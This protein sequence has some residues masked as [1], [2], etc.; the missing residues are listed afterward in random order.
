MPITSYSPDELVNLIQAGQ[1]LNVSRQ[2]V[3]TL[4]DTKKLK[5]ILI[6]GRQYLL[7]AE[8]EALKVDREKNAH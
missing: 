6:G 3:Y 1:L 2:W 8:V 5:P 7:K 4:I